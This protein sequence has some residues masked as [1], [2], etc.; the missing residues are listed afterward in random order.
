MV[1]TKRGIRSGIAATLLGALGLVFGAPAPAKAAGPGL[2]VLV[3]DAS[4]TRL[5]SANETFRSIACGRSPRLIAFSPDPLGY[6]IF[7]GTQPIAVTWDFGAGEPLGGPLAFFSLQPLVSFPP[8]FTL[9]TVTIYG[10][11]APPQPLQSTTFSFRARESV[12]PC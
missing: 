11:G 5:V 12:T 4:G 10:A 9:V 1:N 7:G 8:T 3:S 2:A 6:P